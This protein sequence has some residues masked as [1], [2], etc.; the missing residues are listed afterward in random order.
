M[1]VPAMEP[2]KLTIHDPDEGCMHLFFY[3]GLRFDEPAGL[4]NLFQVFSCVFCQERRMEYADV[5]IHPKLYGATPMT[6]AER[7]AADQI[8]LERKQADEARRPQ[9]T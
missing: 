9:P 3:A 4:V 7:D 5:S 2:D 1:T 6:T 8:L